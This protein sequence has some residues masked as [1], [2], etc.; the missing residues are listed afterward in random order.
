[1]LARLAA[2]SQAPRWGERHLALVAAFAGAAPALGVFGTAYLTAADW[3]LHPP[4]HL[5]IVAGTGPGEAALAREMHRAALQTFAP[6]RVVQLVGIGSGTLPAA[7]AAMQ[8]AADG[9]R[10]YLCIGASCQAPAESLAAWKEA[11]ASVGW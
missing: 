1:M 8:Q 3:A 4:T 6:R 5:V 7:V 9:T 10:G 2:L 11:L